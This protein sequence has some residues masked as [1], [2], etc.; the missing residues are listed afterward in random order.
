VR[1]PLGLLEQIGDAARADGPIFLLLLVSVSLVPGFAEEI[2]FRGVIQRSLTAR[3][4]APAGIGLASTLFGAFHVDPPQAVGAAV[5]GAALGFVV[6]RT[7]TVLPAVL[8]HACNNAIALLAARAEADPAAHLELSDHLVVLGV[9][10]AFLV[11]ASWLLIRVTR[12]TET[13]P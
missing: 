10:G 2:F 9:A 3:Y 5:L 6:W 7:K 13:L 11:L 12:S 1:A 4:G 8:A